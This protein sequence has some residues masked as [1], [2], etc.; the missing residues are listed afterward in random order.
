MGLLV[1]LN[2]RMHPI[3]MSSMF[4]SEWYL[5]DF[6]CSFFVFWYDIICMVVFSFHYDLAK[7]MT[8]LPSLFLVSNCY[9]HSDYSITYLDQDQWDDQ[10]NEIA[11]SLLFDLLTNLLWLDWPG[12][13]IIG[14]RLLIG[15]MFKFVDYGILYPRYFHSSCPEKIFNALV[16][17]VL[18]HQ[19]PYGGN[20][21]DKPHFFWQLALSLGWC[22]QHHDHPN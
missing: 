12:D 2:W 21:V 19:H 3:G 13:D 16:I 8:F 5:A 10:T 15:V 1:F 7:G 17:F 20:Q 18:M 14:L 11:A 4:F 6:T 22:C 9:L